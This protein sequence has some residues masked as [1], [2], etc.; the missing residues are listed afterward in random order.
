MASMSLSFSS[1]LCSSRIPEAKRT[2]HHRDASFVRCVLAA[3]KSSPGGATKKRLWK[4]GEFPGISEPTNPRRTP[5]KN[6]KKK[7]DRRS[8]ANGWVNTVTETLSDCIAKKQWLQAL[9]VL[10]ILSS[11]SQFSGI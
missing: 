11:Q 8:K 5:I 7:L 4:E 9:E 10:Q 1:S 3:S 6:V 2:F